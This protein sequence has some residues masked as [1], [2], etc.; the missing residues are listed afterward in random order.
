MSHILTYSTNVIPRIS[1]CTLSQWWLIFTKVSF[2]VVE[3]KFYGKQTSVL[4][5]H[6]ILM[7]KCQKQFVRN[8]EISIYYYNMS[9]TIRRY[10]LGPEMRRNHNKTQLLGNKILQISTTVKKNFVTENS[11]NC[12]AVTNDLPKLWT[13]KIDLQ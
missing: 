4:L 3:N 13:L 6:F 5:K 8:V 10:A 1:I 7:K 11:E 12:R 2:R 9:V